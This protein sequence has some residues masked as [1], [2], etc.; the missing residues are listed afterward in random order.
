M[1]QPS[2]FEFLILGCA[3]AGT[4]GRDINRLGFARIEG[5][6]RRSKVAA[7]AAIWLACR[8]LENGCAL[9]SGAITLAALGQAGNV[10]GK[11]C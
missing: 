8:H 10:A 2:G 11:D 7:K 4:K 9:S 6:F 5:G 1:G 3:F